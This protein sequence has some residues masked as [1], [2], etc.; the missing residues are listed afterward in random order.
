M[1]NQTPDIAWVL[2]EDN[3]AIMRAAVKYSE[4]FGNAPKTELY[5]LDVKRV[6]RD[7]ESALDEV[8]E[9]TV[10]KALQGSLLN[11]K[12]VQES[13]SERIQQFNKALG[14]GLSDGRIFNPHTYSPATKSE[15]KVDEN[16]DFLDI[17]KFSV[18]ILGKVKLDVTAIVYSALQTHLNP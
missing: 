18:N 12:V 14:D 7:L 1:S 9:G 16:P 10:L 3:Q 13:A 6:A 11:T 15:T 2:E 5:K 17:G 4:K 8:L